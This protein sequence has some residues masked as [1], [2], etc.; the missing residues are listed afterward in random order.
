[1]QAVDCLTPP[2]TL[3]LRDQRALWHPFV[4]H[5]LENTFFPVKRG[6]NAILELMDG[7]RIIDAISS[8]W[9]NLHGHAHPTIAEAIYAQ[10]QQLEQVV[11]SSFTHEPAI[12]LAELLINAMQARGANLSRCFYS[13]NGST[14]VEVAMKMAYQ[15][16]RNNG[17]TTRTRFLA[18]HDGYHGDTLGSMAVSARGSYHEQF[19]ALFPEVDF[20]STQDIKQ[21]ENYLNQY[22]NQ[23]AALLIEPMV[24]ASGGM[25]MYSAQFL[26][27]AA[28]LCKQAGVLLICDEVFTGFYRTGR[29][30]AFEYAGIQPDFVCLAKGLTGGFLPLGATLVTEQLF[31]AYYCSD[32]KR[33]LWHGHSYTANPLACAAAIASWQL[34]HQPETQQAIARITQHTQALVTQLA[35][36]ENCGATR[37]LGTV[38]VVEKRNTGGYMAGQ[39]PKIRA[40]AIQH[41]V[42]LR[43]LGEALCT[44]PPYCISEAELDKVYRVIEIILDQ[45]EL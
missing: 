19:N 23:Y 7:R 28:A 37:A 38:G 45:E 1:M 12:K 26:Q 41:G 32:M 2:K 44:V 3:I 15:Y 33:A 43:P 8:W 10:A 24:Q 18:C 5:G 40:F 9:V 11:F 25:K 31:Q 35:S 17:V 14:A 6:Y 16:H 30:F 20:I 21:L 36:H 29:C 4:Q 13:D 34:L 27:Q 42:L 22:P 39:G